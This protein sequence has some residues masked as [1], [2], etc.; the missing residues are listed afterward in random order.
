LSPFA[1]KSHLSIA[2]GLLTISG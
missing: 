2:N 1:S